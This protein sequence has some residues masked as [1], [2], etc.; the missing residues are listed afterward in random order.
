[1]SYSVPNPP[2]HSQQIYCQ[3]NFSAT[4]GWAQVAI[5]FTPNEN[6]DMIWIFPK[7]TSTPNPPA[8]LNIG[9]SY[10]EIISNETFGAGPQP[11][12]TPGNCTVTIGPA[13]PNC[14]VKNAVFKWYG[15]NGQIISAPANQQIQV[16]AGNSNN[17]GNW[18]LIMTV[19]GSNPYGT[20]SCS[21]N[22][23]VQASVLVTSCTGNCTPA[24]QVSGYLEAEC[25]PHQIPIIPYT[26]NSYCWGS[27]CGYHTYF[28]SNYGSGNEWYVND[29]LFTGSGGTISG[30]GSV[31]IYNNSKNLTFETDA[32]TATQLFKFQV[33]NSTFGCTQ[34]TI[35]TY[36]YAGYV[37]GGFMG[38]YKP[39]FSNTYNT[40]PP[41]R[42]SA[43][44]GSIYTWSVP[45]TVITDSD[46]YTP[47]AI[48]Y[49]PS[50]IPLTRVS[51]SITITNSPYCNG[52]YPI[53]F[54]YNPNAFSKIADN[55]KSIKQNYVTIYPNPV[56]N[57]ITIRSK[58]T[59]SDIK[60]SD[61]MN[62]ILKRI[63]ANNTKS[64][65][66]NVSDL[67]PGIYN[68]KITTSKGTEN[69]KLI[70]KR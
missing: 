57:Q 66:I 39:N 64:I 6:Y 20:N 7:V 29:I 25:P 19:P 53:Y 68:C 26:Q 22:M 37:P 54:D 70:I 45:N 36:V 43:G 33:K 52:T 9:F 41:N 11:N 18:T 13:T 12:P 63:K 16:D 32:T 17:V 34:L 59:I 10:P 21:S 30:L 27:D 55:T 4:S 42:N 46:P 48:V 28:E 14:G 47:D 65:T 40:F 23:N 8:V 5:D 67:S 69:Q 56:S 38:W 60:I 50:N 58:E 35:P 15:P 2:P 31:W 49:F 24:I 44:P 3:K 51:G 62:P 61:L 1:M